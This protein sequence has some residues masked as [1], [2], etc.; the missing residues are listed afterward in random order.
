MEGKRL[1]CQQTCINHVNNNFY[2]ILSAYQGD[3]TP[4]AFTQKLFPNPLV[5]WRLRPQFITGRALAIMES[6][7]F[8]ATVRPKCWD[9]AQFENGGA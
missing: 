8:F 7:T 3:C 1:A 9:V 6:R 4:D 2:I 5:Y